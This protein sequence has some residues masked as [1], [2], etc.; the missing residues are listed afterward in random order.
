M[1]PYFWF[2]PHGFLREPGGWRLSPAYDLNPTP[3]DVKPRVHALAL[4]ETDQD[5]SLDTA[6]G[7][8]SYFRLDKAEASGIARDVGEVV[9]TWREVAAQHG[10]NPNQID[11]VASAFEHADLTAART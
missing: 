5:A 7:V 3:V 11:R 4:N 6:L 2:A 9:A 10:L 8:A 1:T